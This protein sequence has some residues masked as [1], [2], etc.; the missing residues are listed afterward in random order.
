M[1]DLKIQVKEPKATI[2]TITQGNLT[3]VDIVPPTEE[4]IKF[5]EDRYHFQKLALEDCL[6]H[7][8]IS[9]MDVFPD[10]LF[11]VF[12]FNHYN[13]I[14]RISM[15]KQWSAFIGKDFIITVHTGDLKT[16]VELF[17]ECE[18]NSE[19]RQK[20]MGYGSGFMLFQIIDQA[21]DSYFPVM[22][23]IFNLLEQTE[24]SV[25]DEEAEATME[26]S[27]LRRDIIT[28]RMV[29]F[30][31]RNLLI[32]MRD[33]LNLY[34]RID[35]T[36]EY[37]D[38]IDHLNK[39]CQTLDECKEVVEVFKDTDY[40]LVTQRLNRVVRILNVFATIVLPFLA[41]SS[42]Y[43]MNVPLPGGL[44]RDNLTTFFILLAVMI[45]LTV[46]M[47]IYFRKRHWV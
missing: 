6:S 37:D 7:R 3:W 47:L 24:D 40:T 15:K 21:I 29:M 28:Q 32:E 31:T 5:L 19:S 16:I 17:R 20:Y 42:I 14:T 2:R 11:F 34:S 45:G 39:I 43:G 23:K 27:I 18:K 10:Y 9:K 22:D 33:K 46:V 30:P 1:R 35:L 26:V 8:Q 25:F 4:A 36:E 13:K 38:L 44:E 12:H 41:V